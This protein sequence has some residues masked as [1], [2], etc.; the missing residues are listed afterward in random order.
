MARD[1]VDSSHNM[2]TQARHVHD[3]SLNFAPRR[4]Q[5]QIIFGSLSRNSLKC[6]RKFLAGLIFLVGSLWAPAMAAPIA[7]QRAEKLRKELLYLNRNLSARK[8]RIRT[9][10]RT[11]PR[12]LVSDQIRNDLSSFQ[13]EEIQRRLRIIAREIK[14]VT[15]NKAEIADL[16]NLVLSVDRQRIGYEIDVGFAM[17][18]QLP[19]PRDL[20]L[21][22]SDI[23]RSGETDPK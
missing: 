21:S 9:A 22:I 2:M 11:K 15:T 4:L 19:M 17:T 13:T 20:D 1:I 14:S 7:P 18:G 10:L 12:V 8:S 6:M 3:K 23:L 16:Q 5:I